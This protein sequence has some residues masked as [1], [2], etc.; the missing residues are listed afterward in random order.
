MKVIKRIEHGHDFTDVLVLPT[1]NP[2][3]LFV[4]M[5]ANRKDDPREYC[6]I[7]EG[8]EDGFETLTAMLYEDGKDVKACTTLMVE[9][10][11]FLVALSNKDG[12]GWYEGFLIN[13]N[14]LL[15]NQLTPLPV[16]VK[17]DSA[18]SK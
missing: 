13:K 7:S 5:T 16:T 6:T 14:N 17:D 1:S 11:F 10:E 12:S 15:G 2:D 4:Q 3:I 18:K 8:C 9:G